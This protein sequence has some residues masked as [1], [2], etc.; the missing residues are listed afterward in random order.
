MKKPLVSY[1]PTVRALNPLLHQTITAEGFFDAAMYPI[2]A[3]GGF[4][5]ATSIPRN[6]TDEQITQLYVSLFSIR[7]RIPLVELVEYNAAI[8][9]R[10]YVPR[11]PLSLSGVCTKVKDECK[12]FYRSSCGGCGITWVPGSLI[13]PACVQYPAPWWQKYL[14]GEVEWLIQQAGGPSKTDALIWT[15]EGVCKNGR[16]AN[17]ELFIPKRDLQNWRAAL[18]GTPALKE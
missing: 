2:F 11:I 14:G 18:Y 13:D 7:H 12:H 6:L 8:R 17:R 3:A 16:T 4:P 15:P 10:G 9:Y 5:I 1:L